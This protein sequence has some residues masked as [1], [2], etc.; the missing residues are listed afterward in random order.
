MFIATTPNLPERHWLASLFGKG[1]L[2]TQTRKALLT[3]VAPKGTPDVGN[4]VC[5]CFNVGEKTIRAEI[6]KKNLKT[7]K[8][9]SECLKAG[10][11]CGSCLAEIKG[12]L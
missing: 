12:F 3:G 10:T 6:L 1:Q 2:D 8:E 9:V 4:I 11:N 7:V 5:V